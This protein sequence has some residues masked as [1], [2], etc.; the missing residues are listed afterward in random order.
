MFD[1]LMRGESAVRRIELSSGSDTYSAI[2]APIRGEPWKELPRSQR[3]MT[4]R[5]SQI[6]ILAANSAISD[7]GLNL[8]AEDR[9]RVGVSVGT[10]MGGILSTELAYEDLFRKGLS[11]VSPFTLV[12]TMYNAPAAHIGLLRGISGPSLT[13]TTTCSSSAVSI[14]EAMRAIR[15][16]YADVMIAG[17]ADALLTYGSVKAWQALQI[18][19]P[20]DPENPAATCRP[21]NKNRSGT[22]IGEGAAF[23]VLEEFARAKARHANIYAELAGYGVSTDSA[24]MTQPSEAGQAHAIRL[25]LSDAQLD[26]HAVGYVNAH[27]TATPMNDIVE[28][29]ALKAVF[30]DHAYRI[31]VSSTKS[32]HGHVVGA[33]GALELIISVMAL[34]RQMVPP[35]AHLDAPDPMCDLDYVPNAGR[36]AHIRA[37]LSNSFAFGGTSGVLLVVR[38]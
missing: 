32:M 33:A 3:A 21:F 17:G 23:V 38:D 31:P 10:C 15:H 28:T 26:V 29:N 12:K 37:S 1:A 11:R 30:G 24:H 6:A 16:G 35:T 20:G 34:T 7:A 18:L 14:G 2:A 4:D 9:S 8:D 22:V 13:Y 25:A 19:A 5:V 27:G 36:D